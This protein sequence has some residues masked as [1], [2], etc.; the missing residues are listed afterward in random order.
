MPALFTLA[1]L[2]ASRW[3]NRVGFCP[4]D[5][6]LL[7]LAN[8]AQRRLVDMPARWVGTC[9]YVDLILNGRSWFC[10]PPGVTT[11]LAAYNA[12]NRGR[13]ELLNGWHQFGGIA[14]YAGGNTPQ[15]I[16][17]WS[18]DPAPVFVAEDG[19]SPVVNDLPT[20]PFTVRCYANFADDVGKATRIYG[21]LPF[22]NLPVVGDDGS[23]GYRPGVELLV[24]DR[25]GTI[26]ETPSLGTVTL[27]EKG[28]T[29]GPVDLYAVTTDVEGAETETFIQQLESWETTSIRQRWV[30]NTCPSPCALKAIVKLGHIPVTRDTDFFVL[31]SLDAVGSGVLSLKRHEE[32]AYDEAALLWSQAIGLLDDATR[33]LTGDRVSVN[34]RGLALK[35]RFSGFI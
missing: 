27:I 21:L 30:V 20:V 13:G 18:G 8:E 14:D 24:S 31:A 7:Q 16:Q 11:I 25:E 15:W 2:K 9:Q 12:G 22:E 29:T 1:E 17:P 10:C 28:V 34:S 33:N 5:P 3:P 35:S 19:V 6:R 26:D 32:R 4:T 23:G